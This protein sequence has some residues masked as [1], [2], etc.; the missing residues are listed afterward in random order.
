MKLAYASHDSC[1]HFASFESGEPVVQTVR[2]S[3]LPLMSL[4]F[5]AEKAVVG[6]GHDFNPT[7]YTHENGQWSFK[8][9]LD[10]KSEVKAAA[11]SSVGAARALF[12]NKTS[13]GQEASKEGDTLWTKHE[14][15]I[16]CIRDTSP[17]GNVGPLRKISTSA[18][19]GRI[20]FWDLATL[21]VQLNALHL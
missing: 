16:T 10:S 13:R 19:D 3:E 11:A 21:D 15:V 2:F 9:K 18:L 5:V 20:V 8:K 12:Q 14:N 4:L 1:I 6:G 7:M 17:A